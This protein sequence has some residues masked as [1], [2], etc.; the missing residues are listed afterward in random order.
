MSAVLNRRV[1]RAFGAALCVL[2]AAGT[3]TAT[4]RRQMGSH[5]HGVTILNVA[6]EDGAVLLELEG[7]AMNFVGFEHPPRTDEQKQAIADTVAALRAGDSLFTLSPAAGCTLVSA[8]S[9]HTGDAAHDDHDDHGDHDDHDQHDNESSH[10]EFVA[11]YEFSCEDLS[12]LAELTVN[13]FEQF[14]LTSEVEASF[15]G[16]SFQTFKE[17]TPDS[18]VI[19]LQP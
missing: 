11:E 13:L 5:E 7:P 12:E 3:A 4:E 8:S 19:P 16:A 10:S 1:G 2:G 15:V 17:L 6:A 18:P 14:P 9:E